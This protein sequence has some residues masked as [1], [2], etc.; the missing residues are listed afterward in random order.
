M[1]PYQNLDDGI[2]L[3]DNAPQTILPKRIKM[4]SIFSSVIVSACL[5]VGLFGALFEKGHCNSVLATTTV[6]ES[7]ITL[8]GI[9]LTRLRYRS[10]S[11]WK[12]HNQYYF[13]VDIGGLVV[14]TIVYYHYPVC[15]KQ[16]PLVYYSVMTLLIFNYLYIAF[17]LFS[18]A[19]LI[20][21][22]PFYYFIIR[23][24]VVSKEALTKQ[25]L[26]K[27]P[28]S[29]HQKTEPIPCLICLEDIKPSTEIITL[30][31]SHSFHVKCVQNWLKVKAICPTCRG[32]AKP[33]QV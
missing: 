33:A 12:Q 11:K 2:L 17:I 15:Q 10:L 8:W 16:S 20:V 6:V 13:W 18:L 14:S 31:C 9:Y 19:L 32:S 27:L 30:P 22:A 23:P 29:I 28:R 24:V 25:E 4:Y 21:C 5:G 26:Q 7:L 3:E 1:L